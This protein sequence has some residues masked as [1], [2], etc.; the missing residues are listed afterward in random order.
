MSDLSFLAGRDVHVYRFV[1]ESTIEENM[2]RKANQKR[3]LN[4]VVVE[5]ANLT[6]EYFS[7]T[8]WRDMLGESMVEEL[9]IAPAKGTGTAE[10][11][12]TEP[13]DAKVTAE[14]FAAAEDEEDAAAAQMVEG[15]MELDRPDF[16][17]QPVAASAG[18]E[19]EDRATPATPGDTPAVEEAVA[20]EAEDEEDDLSGTVDGYMLRF[21][22][23]DW[24]FFGP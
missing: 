8:D 17:E 22:D 16:A 12:S 11:S 15:E 14:A 4:N 1:S 23:D 20:E 2:L 24:E 9:G 3:L 7:R 13:P 5:E 6:T 10:L 18:E 21:V 19:K